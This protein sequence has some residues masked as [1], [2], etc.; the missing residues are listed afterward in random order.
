MKVCDLTGKRFGKLVVIERTETPANV[1]AKRP[2]WLCLCDCGKETTVSGAN[3]Q[4]GVSSCGCKRRES[5]PKTHGCASHKKYNRLY[6]IWNGIKYR[7]YNE[8]SK[9]FP[10]YGGRGIKM[11]N[12]WLHDFPA[13]REWA[14]TNG[15]QETLTID[16]LDVNGYYEPKNCRWATVAEQNRNKT[17]TKKE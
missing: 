4:S 16:R 11:C 13:F 8:K 14:Y 15:Y 5:R 2:Y 1:K 6:H 12:E 7:C 10:H 17:T 3:L 9:D